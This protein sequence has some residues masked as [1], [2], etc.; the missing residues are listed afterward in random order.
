MF[1]KLPLACIPALKARPSFLLFASILLFFFSLPSAKA[2][3]KADFTADTLSGCPPLVVKF[4]DQSGGNPTSWK[5]D[6]GTGGN[7][8]VLQNPEKVYNKPG[9][10]TVTLTV[11]DG[12]NNDK[13]IKQQ[14]ITI[15]DTPEVDF[16][17]SPPSGCYPL[18]VHFTDHSEA[19]EG[20]SIQSWLWDFGDGNI[21][22]QPNPSHRYDN[23]GKFNVSLSVTNKAGCS[24]GV[25]HKAAVVT[26]EGVK[27]D[28]TADQTVS[29]TAPMT[30]HFTAQAGSNQQVTY[31]W[32]FGDGESGSGVTAAHTYN[33][34]G[35]YSVTLRA[36]V[37]NGCTDTV[38]K[39][40]FIHA[41][42]FK[43]DFQLPQGCANV[44]LTFKNT[45]SPIPD[46]AVWYFSDGKVIKDINAVHQ[47][48]KPGTY[49]VK[50][51]N[52]Y[53]TCKDEV[54]KTL[55]TF[56]S[57]KADFQ[58]AIQKYCTLPAAVTFENL[59]EDAVS[60]K[61]HFGDSTTS[62]QMAPTHAYQL[63]GVFDVKLRVA[64]EQGCMDSITKTGYIHVNDPEVQ[65]IGRNNSGCVP[66][67]VEFQNEI[68]SPEPITQ[69]FWDF[70]DG[71]TS[72]SA[73]PSHQYTK[74]GTFDVKLRVTTASGCVDSLVRKNFVHTGT[75][76][77]VKFT[78]TPK[79]ACMETP[80]Q[81][82]NLSQPPGM[83]WEWIFPDD[84]QSGS[85][86]EN[87]L[88]RFSHIGQQDVAL[89]VNNNGCE[90]G[91][92]L[93]DFITIKAP[94]ALFQATQACESPYTVT[95]KDKSESAVQWQWDFGDGTT[96]NGQN[97]PPHTYSSTG[98]Y[99]ITLV[100]KN[101]ECTSTAVKTIHIIDLEPVLKV[102]APVVCHGTAL[103]FSLAN[104]RDTAW[105]RSYTWK[106]GDGR[107]FTTASPDTTLVYA[108]NGT[109]EARLITTDI[110]GCT[111]TSAGVQVVVQ[112]P[113]AD[114]V[115]SPSTTC[116][117]NK[118]VFRD[119]STV[120]GAPIQ[121]WR[122]DFGDSTT[123]T[124]SKDSVVHI[125]H[126][127]GRYMVQL[128]VTDENGCS[129]TKKAQT[130]PA[131]IYDVE[132][133]FSTV[134]SMICPG[135]PIHWINESK[136]NNLAYHWD[137]GDNT[138]GDKRVPDKT[139]L[140]EGTYTV[141]L[142]VESPLGCR[143]SI[144]KEQ[145]IKV[146]A[147]HAKMDYA[148]NNASCPPFVVSVTN[149]SENYSKILWDFGDGTV[150]NNTDTARHV[151]T[152]PGNYV[153]KMRVYGYSGGCMDSIVRTVS[154]PGPYGTASVVDS[155][156]CS[157]HSV[158]FSATAVRTVSYR[159]DFGD[160]TISSPSPVDE[161]THTYKEAGVFQP[162]LGLTDDRG[163]LVFIPTK[164]KVTI[165]AVEIAP[166]Y[167]I[168]EICDSSIFQFQAKGQIFSMDSLHFPARF[169]WNFGEPGS[170][171]NTSTLPEPQ[172]DY[173]QPGTY[174]VKVQINTTF[175]CDTEQTVQVVV[176][177][178]YTMQ[179]T[180]SPD[181]AVCRGVPA[182]LRASGAY[183]YSWSPAA[184]LSNTSS[185]TPVA[186][187]EETTTY[188][189]IGYS[190]GDCQSDTANIRLVV[191]DRPEITLP[192]DTTIGTGSSV[193]L[194]ASYSQDAITW[195]WSPDQ[196]LN[197]TDC[198]SPVSTPH[199]PITYRVVTANQWGC[200]DSAAIKINL[201]C[202]QGKVFIP[203][204][205]TPNNDGM[206]D[207]FY[208]RGKG[209]SEVLY[210]RI[211]NRWGQL[212]YVRTHFKLNDKSAGWDG[213]FNDKLL[214]PGV[215]IYQASM[216]CESGDVFKLDG[217]ITLLR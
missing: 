107:S 99:K 86:E 139:Y 154:I 34:S 210:F 202:K 126:E 190:E 197:C 198:A 85:K 124:L 167:T 28:F 101:G 110:N 22:H 33:Q 134:D 183:R 150:S 178:P 214:P 31:L 196:Y 144:T 12:T 205:F 114:F 61:W 191:N 104:T 213:T 18:N 1:N 10:Y 130:N 188:Q 37:V 44:P 70:G 105:I 29:C 160:G 149:K 75:P 123:E 81:F 55:T 80:V 73:N 118:I 2:Q 184:G 27:A 108:K 121:Q 46:S 206:N 58:S 98:T 88:H 147:P 21:S 87:P 136:G 11:G 138:T 212:V 6:F 71:T 177:E 174:P 192:T 181:T 186:L 176:P 116:S 148:D 43:S 153:L 119:N 45:S 113:E 109:Y 122:W 41:G 170:A 39:K 83:S 168:P 180:T 159:W 3:L 204:T 189:V 95:V 131:N 91:D 155:V 163:C 74:E 62:T 158:R 89:I 115:F 100:A 65:F 92:T 173:A 208:P 76:P 66:L 40:N 169:Q 78:A 82:T 35:V 90:A 162:Q 211:Y 165:D 68:N 141:S 93:A 19:G 187:P 72:T 7:P 30:V 94:K 25:T 185:A 69:Y 47:F 64:N 215:F 38:V 50:L 51:V 9:T 199:R 203:N 133:A 175:G 151:Y 26:N 60:A 16:L 48:S 156:G 194:P 135:A 20:T 8:S 201:V 52:I 142:K 63:N 140:E 127:G 23:A 102:S 117:G 128:E 179:V 143:D 193:Q 53:G 5:W 54:T 120:S 49:T 157:P 59:S 15:A 4:T 146:G 79:T 161:A 216:R 137:F 209:V 172:H 77:E 96:A 14:Y 171:D 32:D 200:T 42:S 182:V 129:D 24:S 57:P 166:V 106:T 145:Y 207:V 112:G 217:N 195:N 164:R 67:T 17:V 56:P 111:D 132:A 152:I 103:N 84:D 125:Y 36:S 97:P 13:I